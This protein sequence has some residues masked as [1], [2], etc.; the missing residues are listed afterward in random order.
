MGKL[1]EGSREIHHSSPFTQGARSLGRPSPSHAAPKDPYV[2]FKSQRVTVGQRP[3][4]GR[5]RKAAAHA[6]QPTFP[7]WEVYT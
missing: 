4:E 6:S 2:L 3:P 5:H 1:P 7:G